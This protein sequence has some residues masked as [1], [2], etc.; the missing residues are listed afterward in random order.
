ML[1]D[2]FVVLSD[3]FDVV[4]YIILDKN[5]RQRMLQRMFCRNQAAE[6]HMGHTGHQERHPT[7]LNTIPGSSQVLSECGAVNQTVDQLNENC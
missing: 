5:V 6:H 2:I 3:I 7:E 4:I 1:K